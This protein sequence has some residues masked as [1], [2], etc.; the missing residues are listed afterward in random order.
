MK[1]SPL[2]YFS[3]I[4]L[5]AIFAAFL[6]HLVLVR[7][8]RLYKEPFARQEGVI[9]G[10]FLGFIPLSIIFFAWINFGSRMSGIDIFW[11]TIYIYIIYCLFSYVYFHIFNMSETARRIRILLE[12]YKTGTVEKELLTR[13]YSSE[14]MLI[15]RLKRL[16]SL[17]QLCLRGDKYVIKNKLLLFPAR[18]VFALRKVLFPELNL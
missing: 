1:E 3:L 9:A 15:N 18:V 10:F 8:F 6:M 14:D 7:L 17:R 11:S 5:F 4:V 16:T 13:N 12:I 2:L